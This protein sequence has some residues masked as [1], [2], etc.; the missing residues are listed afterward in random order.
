MNIALIGYGKMGKEI[1]A[2]AP[3]QGI[4]VVARFDID[5]NRSGS[6]LTPDAL[7]NVQVC[8]DFSVPSEVIT[9]LR[10][11]AECGKNLVIGTTGWYDK[12]D[13]ARRIVNEKQIGLVYSANFAIGMNVFLKLLEEA[14]KMVDRFEYDVAIQETHHRE[15][16]DSPSGTALEIGKILLRSFKRKKELLTA[17]PEGT[18]RPEQLQISSTRVGTVGGIHAV[19]FDS[20]AD[21]IELKHTAKSRAGFALGALLAAKWIDGRRGLYSMEDVMKDIFR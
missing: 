1:D 16:L 3:S 17:K 4:Q 20:L 2:F 19:S 21:T 14:G 8:V 5:N 6:G 7:K 18:L 13:E 10:R 11:V 15:K 12:L 9:N